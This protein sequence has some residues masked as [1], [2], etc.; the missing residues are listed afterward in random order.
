MVFIGHFVV[1][2]YKYV[3]LACKTFFRKFSPSS[4]NFLAQLIMASQEMSPKKIIQAMS[5]CASSFRTYFFVNVLT[6]ETLPRDRD[7]VHLIAFIL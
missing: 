5:H 4:F 6:F 3:D 1:M 7:I 2:N